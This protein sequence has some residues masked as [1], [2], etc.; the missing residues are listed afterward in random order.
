MF[1]QRKNI[2]WIIMLTISMTLMSG[3]VFAQHNHDYGTTSPVSGQDQKLLDELKG[4]DGKQAME[5][6]NKWRQRNPDITS[7]VTPDAVNFKFKDGKTISVPLPDDQMVV[8]IAPYIN[9]T[10]KCATHYMS[11]C[12]AE[13]KNVPLKVLAIT[14]EGKTVIDKTFK[15]PSTGF[16]DLWLPRDQEIIISVSARGK[17][18]TGKI[19]TY[20]NSKTCDTTLKLE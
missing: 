5:L 7:F 15:T 4:I 1:N 3:L 6:A 16:F 12:D 8:S 19:Y 14:A 20:R 9:T 17:K 18:A 2:P 11:K 10:H 13:L